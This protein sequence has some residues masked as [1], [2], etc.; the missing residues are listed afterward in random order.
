MSGTIRKWGYRADDARIF[1]V[2]ADTGA[3]PDGWHESP[4]LVPK[5]AADTPPAAAHIEQP[6]AKEDDLTALR[7]RAAALGIKIDGRWSAAKLTRVINEV[8]SDGN[9]S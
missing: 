6:V 4:D 8:E 7:Y 2:P 9:G 1:D 3:L 5:V